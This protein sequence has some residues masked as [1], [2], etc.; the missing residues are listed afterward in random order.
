[1]LRVDER[2]IEGREVRAPGV[3]RSFEGAER[4]IYAK[5]AEHNKNDENL[6]P[7]GIPAESA[8]EPR[9]RQ[10]RRGTRHRVT[11]EVAVG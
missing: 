6:D 10:E 3:I 4:G 5:T 1:M 11:S 2:R 7:P 8:A 9:P